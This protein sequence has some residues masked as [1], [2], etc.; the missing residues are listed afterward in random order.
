MR[1]QYRTQRSHGR[2]AAA[3]AAAAAAIGVA[4]TLAAGPAQATPVQARAAVVDDV[5]TISGTNA[6]DQI[7]VDFTALDSVVVDLGG[8]SGPRRFDRSTF[9]SAS[10]SLH[11]GD[12]DFRTLTGG[13]LADVP[14]TITTGAGNDSAVMGAGNDVVNGGSGEDFLLGGAGTDLVVSGTGADFVNGGVGTDVEVLGNG[15]DT[16]AWNPGEGNDTVVG[17]H[18]RDTLAFN[19]SD[20]DELMSLSANGQS[21]VFLRSPGNIRMDLESVE[22]LDLATFGGS[23]AVTIGDLSGTDVT[24]A[25][26]DLA[27]TRGAADARDDTVRVTG[28]GQA[29]HVDVTADGGAVD[30]AGLSARTVVTGGDPTDRLQIDTLGGDDRVNVTDGARALLDIRS[31]LGADQS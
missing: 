29:D 2:A 5:L 26:I 23:D 19:G 1:V 3:A 6:A 16:A 31:D 10:V 24:V 25:E 28:S 17:G 27:S 30:V 8:N 9:H 12:D 7:T 14:M 4:A 20:A 21:A 18:G 15:D 13:P 11:A 22:R